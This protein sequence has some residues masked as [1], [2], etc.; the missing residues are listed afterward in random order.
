M[1][2]N[3]IR[4]QIATLISALS[5]MQ[6][7]VSYPKLDF[8]GYPSAYII[9][10]DSESDYETNIENQRVY[11]FIIRVFY[12]IKNTGVQTALDNL[13]DAVDDII[14]AIDK[15]DKLGNTTRTI[16]MNLPA[17]YTY[18]SISATPSNWG[19]IPSENLIMAEIRVR[20]KVSY[21][22]S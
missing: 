15:E 14:D 6:E 5:K 7:V 22:A 19:E 3:V 18:L 17:D 16:G 10:S 8:S 1:S 21:D 4:P 9:P 12:E 11:A 20:I 2:Y 13:E